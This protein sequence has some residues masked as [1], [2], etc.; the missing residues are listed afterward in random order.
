MGN[1]PSQRGTPN[2][3][4]R[5]V[6][7]DLA[8]PFLT[9]NRKGRGSK[10]VKSYLCLF[11]S[12]RYKCIHLEAVSN[13]TKDAFVLTF[14]RFVS[15]RGK[16]AEVFC[17]N[18]RNF[19]AGA[20]ELNYFFKNH[21]AFL[22]DF[23]SDEGTKFIFS[24]SYAPHFDG[25]WEAGVKSAKFH[26]KRTIGNSHLKF[27]ELT[28]LFAQV[29]SILNSPPLCP[30]SSS[31][32][33]LQVLT[34]GPFLIGRTLTALPSPALDD[35]NSNHLQRYERIQQIYH[36]FWSRWQREYVAELQ[37]RFKWKTNCT[38]L[39]IGDM[40]LLQEDNAP[41]LCWRF[42]R[43]QKL[44]PGQDGVPRVA[45]VDTTKGCV[46]RPVVRLCP[47]PTAEDFKD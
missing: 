42:R 23:A 15:R 41:P 11:I 14:R 10:L 36:H 47:L 29:E 6:C 2:F 37:Q 26:I 1:L 17:D 12:L 4:F 43:V 24:P 3:P 39:N 25:I 21:Q 27:E 9:L 5:T 18:G 34:P 28:T 33:D 20:K 22:S 30:L 8:G 7:I 45:D 46:R 13:L 35:L 31:P 32:D 16:P 44:Y 40:V 38:S 19:V